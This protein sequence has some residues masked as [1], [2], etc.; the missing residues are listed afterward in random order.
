M[1]N[2]N[3]AQGLPLIF[4]FVLLY[5]TPFMGE[6]TGIHYQRSNRTSQV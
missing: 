6:E 2:E 5:S 3:E 1:L 4:H